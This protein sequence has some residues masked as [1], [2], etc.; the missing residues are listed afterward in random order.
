MKKLLKLALVVSM[1]VGLCFSSVSAASYTTKG[2]KFWP[3]SATTDL[4]GTSLTLELEAGTYTAGTYEVGAHYG[5]WLD[6]QITTTIDTTEP[7]YLLATFTLSSS[8]VNALKTSSKY[9]TVSPNF[10]FG[11]S[12]IQ[13]A[14]GSGNYKKYEGAVKPSGGS[15]STGSVDNTGLD[16]S[17]YSAMNM[18]VYPSSRVT[19]IKQSGTGFLVEGY[20]FEQAADCIYND[21]RNWREIVFVNV[22]DAST[23]KAYRKQVTAVYNTWLNSNM[24]ATVNGKYKLNYANYTVTV[25]PSS[26]N[27]YAGNVPGQK[28]AAG[29]YYVYMRISNGKTSYLFPLMD[30]TLNDGTNMENTGTLPTGFTVYDKTTRALMYTVK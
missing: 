12:N 16:L 20:M 29:N 30:K 24:T 26:M 3:K 4:N 23:A 18:T 8:D 11:V 5:I 13:L 28:M 7:W 2:S 19:K 6:S 9:V 1:M 22:N 15:S 25:N 17:A 27:K 10:D 14:V 21:A